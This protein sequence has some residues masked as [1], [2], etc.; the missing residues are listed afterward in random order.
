MNNAFLTG[1]RAYGTVTPTSDTDVVVL[2]SRSDAFKLNDQADQPQPSEKIYGDD[3]DLTMR[4]GKLN[5]IVCFEPEVFNAWDIGTATL[6][7]R[8]RGHPVTRDEAKAVLQ[9]LC[10]AAQD[11][12]RARIKGEAN[13]KH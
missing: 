7:L 13:E 6:R 8:A 1:S 3:T 4:F 11:A 10:D 9:P 5:L 2:M 12:A